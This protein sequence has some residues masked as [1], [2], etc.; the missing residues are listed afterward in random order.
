MNTRKRV[1]DYEQLWKSRC[2]SNGIPD[3]A[4]VEIFKMVPSYK[5]IAISLLNNDYQLLSLGY[6]PKHSEW[7]DTLKKIELS[8][9]GVDVQL[10]LF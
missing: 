2:Y 6:A 3:E 4:P 5:R 8:S 9:R 1:E 10:K 7:Y